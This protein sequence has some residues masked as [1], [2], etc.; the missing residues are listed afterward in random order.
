MIKTTLLCFSFL[1]S[2]GLVSQADLIGD[3]S[4][5]GSTSATGVGTGGSTDGW[6]SNFVVLEGPTDINIGTYL[7][8]SGGPVTIVPTDWS[9]EVGAVRAAVTP[10]I[11]KLNAD[12]DF[13][14]AAIGTTRIATNDYTAVGVNTFSFGGAAFTLAAGERIGAGFMDSDINGENGNGSVIRYTNA[15]VTVGEQW[16]DG[17]N[18][19][20]HGAP[21]PLSLGQNIAG[22][23]T[24]NVQNRLYHFNVE[25]NVIPEPGSGPLM[26]MGL[27]CLLGGAG[28]RIARR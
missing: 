24:S 12:N 23:T 11:L 21:A 4:G 26:L 27:T 10:I 20:P 5:G 17:Q 8:S 18:A 19:I 28:R 15:A 3:I 1:L 2:C 25:F 22:A 14:I 13:T 7:N 6:V 9:M 16:Y